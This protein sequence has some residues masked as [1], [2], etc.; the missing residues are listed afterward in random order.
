MPKNLSSV[1]ISVEEF[2]QFLDTN[3]WWIIVVGGFIMFWQ[4]TKFKQKKVVPFL[5]VTALIVGVFFAAGGRGFDEQSFRTVG[6]TIGNLLGQGLLWILAKVS[7]NSILL[8][9]L[10]ALVA[11]IILVMRMLRLN[12][13]PLN[14]GYWVSVILVLYSG[15]GGTFPPTWPGTSTILT[16]T[17][18]GGTTLT[19]GVFGFLDDLESTRIGVAVASVVML[20]VLWFILTKVG[21]WTTR[22]READ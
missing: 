18:N 5:I 4:V 8:I 12:L 9:W 1:P 20:S 2:R 13:S 11:V 6:Q 17:V 22:A 19:H 7:E 3:L 21:Q 10:A 15:M 14:I 16:E